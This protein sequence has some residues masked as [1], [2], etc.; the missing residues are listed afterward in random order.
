[1]N[2]ILTPVIKRAKENDHRLELITGSTI[3]FWSLENPEGSRG[4]R[5]YH[6]VINE[7]ALVKELSFIFNT[8]IRPTLTDWEGSADFGSTPRGLNDFYELYLLSE[9]QPDTW[10]S[11]HYRT[12]DNPFLPPAEVLSLRQSLPERVVLQEI[13]AEFIED[14]SFFQKVDE[15]AII[16]ERSDP[17]LHINHQIAAGLDWGNENNYTVLTIGCKNCNRV[18]DWDRFNMIGYAAQRERL[19]AKLKYWHCPVLPERNSIGLPNIEL[20]SMAG[21]PII[22]GPDNL[23]G[24]DTTGITKPLLIQ[25]MATGLEYDNFLIPK[26]FKQEFR[27]YE[28]SFTPSGHPTFA[29]PKGFEDD[30]VISTSLLWWALNNYVTWDGFEELGSVED[31]KSRWA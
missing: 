7:A 15:C 10:A 22:S 28:L 20:L 13:D 2:S 31:F 9:K 11:F 3:D 29:A 16:E 21:I 18:V 6:V 1:M 25:K 5:Y 27:I 8:V 23:P 19:R 4:R 24:F 26:D 17:N 12:D 30:E 14:G